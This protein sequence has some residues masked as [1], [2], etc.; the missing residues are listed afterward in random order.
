MEVCVRVCVC[1]RKRDRKAESEGYG[2]TER[3]GETTKPKA[4]FHTKAE[5]RFWYA[6]T[7]VALILICLVVSGS[8]RTGEEVG[9]TARDEEP[10]SPTSAEGVELGPGVGDAGGRVLIGEG[11]K[12]SATK[13]SV[14]SCPALPAPN[15]SC[16]IVVVCL[17]APVWLSA[18]A[19]GWVCALSVS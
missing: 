12:S 13:V 1:G 19:V 7:E 17:D 11:T 9:G 6:V 18:P 3:E 16:V 14:S 15:P 2:D 4:P 10:S 5:L 8:A